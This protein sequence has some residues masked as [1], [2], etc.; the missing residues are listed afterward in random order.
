MAGGGTYRRG[1][2]EIGEQR[3]TYVGVMKATLWSTVFV[4]VLLVLMAIF[5]L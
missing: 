4:V 2:M 3:R 1:T 5:L